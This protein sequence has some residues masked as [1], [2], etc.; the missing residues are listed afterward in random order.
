MRLRIAILTLTILLLAGPSV[1]AQDGPYTPWPPVDS[2][3]TMNFM[4]VV[5][6]AWE[7]PTQ[8]MNGV[9]LHIDEL[10]HYDLI[11][12]DVNRQHAYKI[13]SPANQADHI[14]AAIGEHCAV[15]RAVDTD[16]R[17]SPWSKP[18]CDSVSSGPARITLTSGG[19]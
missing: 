5:T 6:Y 8:R 11:I 4:Q 10:S 2:P 19:G 13:P 1:F 18:V 15:I 12:K 17:E 14:I 3:T 16:G 9:P 7:T